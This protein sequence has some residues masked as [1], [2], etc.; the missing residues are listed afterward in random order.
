M[1]AL[2]TGALAAAVDRGAKEVGPRVDAGGVDVIVLG[3]VAHGDLLAQA[4]A[5]QAG[6]EDVVE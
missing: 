6:C 4:Y 5:V 1:R 2:G 3:E